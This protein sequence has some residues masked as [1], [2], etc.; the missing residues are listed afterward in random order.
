MDDVDGVVDGE[1][2]ADGEDEYG[3]RVEI[4][5]V[6]RT[7]G[8][9]ATTPDQNDRKATRRMANMMINAVSSDE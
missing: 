8:K 3:S 7:F 9:M 6:G 1:A 4:V 2:D 5:A